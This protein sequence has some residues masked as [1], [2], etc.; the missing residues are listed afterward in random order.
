MSVPSMS[1]SSPRRKV[2][3]R[4]GPALLLTLLHRIYTAVRGLRDEKGLQVLAA[5]LTAPSSTWA[6]LLTYA[7][8][9][10]GCAVLIG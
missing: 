4:R 7:A 3:Y 6:A 8:M 10:C 2:T 5:K 1:L 9:R